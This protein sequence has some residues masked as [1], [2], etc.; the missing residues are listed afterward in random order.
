LRPARARIVGA[1]AKIAVT[2]E[3]SMRDNPAKRGEKNAA[4]ALRESF[5][6]ALAFAIPPAFVGAGT[7]SVPGLSDTAVVASLDQPTDFTWTPDG[8]MLVLEKTG[9]VRIVVGGVLQGSPALSLSVDSGGEKGLLGICLDPNFMS[10]GYLYLYYTTTAPANRISRFTMTGDSLNPSSEF[11][12]LDN[13]DATSGTRNGGTLAIGPDGKLWAAPGDSGSDPQG[14]KAQNLSPGSLN[15]KVLRLELDGS[16]AAGNPYLG[17]VAKEARI[18]AY[19][20]RNPFRFTFRPGNGA[21]FAADVG[22]LTWEEIDV[23]TAGGNYGW[24]AAEGPLGQSGCAGCIPPVFSYDHGAGRTI[25]G[26]VFVA[27]ASYP[28]LQGKYVFGD[29]VDDWIRFLEFDASNAVVG[30]IQNLATAAEGPVS[31]R[32]GPDGLLY[33]AAIK[34]GAIYR[35]NPP[36]ARFHTVAPCR[37]L[38][39]RDAPGSFGGPAL[40]AGTVRTFALTGRCGIPTTARTLSGNVTVTAPSAA[41][42]LR[43]FPGGGTVPPTSTINF[44]AG[45]T[46]ANNAVLT[47]SPTGSLSVRCD[48]ASGGV[49]LILDVNGYFE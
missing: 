13:I 40:A 21:F 19:G 34:S 26:G 12:L 45:Q 2:L 38:D 49:Q 29:Y 39:T 43:F 41:G 22:E 31:F 14:A 23:I 5:L 42:D 25:I 18:F 36:D 3:L 30:G 28:G 4:A 15:G 32:N 27:G 16:P 44:R 8:R 11:V 48:M 17:D 1:E 7:Y 24:P 37:T 9:K 33:Y 10:N 46:R 35:M 47:L 20:F 6:L